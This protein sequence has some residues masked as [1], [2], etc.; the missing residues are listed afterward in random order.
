MPAAR[1]FHH[2]LSELPPSSSHC[3]ST[4]GP[5]SLGVV[6]AQVA[7]GSIRSGVYRSVVTPVPNG[8]TLAAFCPRSTGHMEPWANEPSSWRH[9]VRG[10]F[11][12]NIQTFRGCRG[13]ASPQ[14][15][16]NLLPAVRR[17]YGGGCPGSY[18][19][20]CALAGVFRRSLSTLLVPS[21]W[22]NVFL[23]GEVAVQD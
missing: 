4:P 22:G 11:T 9:W 16:H 14:K 10:R 6:R 19:H 1:G 18:F 8:L 2:V 13:R 20:V 23:V 21:H 17:G 5:G 7:P 12:Y 3:S 15:K